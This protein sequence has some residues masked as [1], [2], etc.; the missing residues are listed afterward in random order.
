MR[1]NLIV[2]L[3]SRPQTHDPPAGPWEWPIN[4]SLPVYHQLEEDRELEEE[5]AGR[6][7]ISEPERQSRRPI[8]FGRRRL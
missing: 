5:E 3:G 4:E 8:S 7:R 1:T 6:A 2:W